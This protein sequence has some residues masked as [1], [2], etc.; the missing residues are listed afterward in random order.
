MIQY[1]SF[2]EADR[3]KELQRRA[4]QRLGASD[5]WQITWEEGR[6]LPRAVTGTPMDALEAMHAIEQGWIRFVEV[7]VP[8]AGGV[9]VS[10]GLFVW[11]WE[12][13][14]RISA[15]IYFRNCPTCGEC[16]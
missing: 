16:P 2:V 13:D 3:L 1:L 7:D 11:S 5:N 12:H 14:T 6:S 4:A 9:K 10:A 15:Q 8:G